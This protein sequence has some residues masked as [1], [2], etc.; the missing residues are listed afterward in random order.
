[1]NCTYLNDRVN[2]SDVKSKVGHVN[3]RRAKQKRQ[4]VRLRLLA[5]ALFKRGKSQET[6]FNPILQDIL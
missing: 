2:G 6:K 5:S 4:R 3:L 1:M